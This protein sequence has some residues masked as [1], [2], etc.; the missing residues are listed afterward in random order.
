MYYCAVRFEDETYEVT[1][2]NE[3]ESIILHTKSH[4]SSGDIERILGNRPKSRILVEKILPDSKAIDHLSTFLSDTHHETLFLTRSELKEIFQR[5]QEVVPHINDTH[6]MAR[7]ALYHWKS[8]Q[9]PEETSGGFLHELATG[10][11]EN[12]E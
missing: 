10:L 12:E 6:Q 2:I 11:D 4:P 3:G 8:E 1:I 9:A 5:H 7:L